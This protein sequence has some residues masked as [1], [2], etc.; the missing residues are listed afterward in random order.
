METH[1]LKHTLKKSSPF[2]FLSHFTNST[3]HDKQSQKIQKPRIR[4][5]ESEVSIF[6]QVGSLFLNLLPAF[7]DAGTE[8]F[9]GCD[10]N[11]FNLRK[12]NASRTYFTTLRPSYFRFSL[13][14]GELVHLPE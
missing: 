13:P 9:Q 12:L 11:S 2:F 4:L 6:M 10:R 3:D 8:A 1:K 5:A 14:N 7:T